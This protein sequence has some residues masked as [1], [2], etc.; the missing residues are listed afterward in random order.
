MK[1]A[2]D[3]ARVF[4]GPTLLFIS[5]LRE[6]D[7]V[8]IQAE[9][10][11]L[12]RD[13]SV[14]VQVSSPFVSR[15]HA[16][17]HRVGGYWYITDLFS[18][19]GIFINQVRVA[20]GDPIALRDQDE[21]QIGSVTVFKFRD[22]EAT[23]HESQIQMRSPGLWLD[24]PNRDVYLQDTR[25]APPL[26][27]QQ[28]ALLS[29]LFHRGHA[30]VTN[31]EIAEVLW[32]EA[33]GGVESA[34]IDNAISRLRKRLAELDSGHDYIETVRGVGKRLRQRVR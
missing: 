26:T 16:E 21:V 24:E 34:A 29:L 14:D 32:P 13:P 12:G 28:F 6:G 11:I 18:K 31:E 1:R 22:P 27:P 20:P 30:V 2:K 33:A 5:G 23:I 25:L 4:A 19:N 9:S 15:Q 17:I 8:Q 7:W 3:M 10:C